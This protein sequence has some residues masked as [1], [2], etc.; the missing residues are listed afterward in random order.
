MQKQTYTFV[1]EPT[2]DSV[3]SNGK[4][5][6]TTEEDSIVDESV[7]LNGNSVKEQTVTLSDNEDSGSLEGCFEDLTM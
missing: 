2:E 3:K 5:T 6:K 4:E 7:L 1:N